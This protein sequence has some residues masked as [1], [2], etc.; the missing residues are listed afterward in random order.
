L[1]AA[2]VTRTDFIGG[3]RALGFQEGDVAFVHSSLSS[4]GHVEGGA[5]GVVR[6]L[7]KVLGPE[8][9]LAVP[10]FRR[11]FWEGPDQVWDRDHSPSLMGIISETVRAW[12]GARK[13]HHA[14]HPIAAVGRLAEDL[15]ERHNRSD[16]AFD[17]PFA[18]LLELDAWIVLMG[19]D[20]S[21]CTLIH[22]L[23]ERC[24]IP[25]RY[26]V[27]LTG[28]VVEGGA[29]ARKTYSFM[30]RREGVGNDFLPLGERLEGE[31]LVNAV[32][33]GK[34]RVRCFRARDLYDCGL[35]SLRQDPLFLVSG[36]T[37]VEAE[38][39]LPGHGEILDEGAMRPGTLL[40]PAHPAARRLVEI[41][42]LR[43]A[44][45][46]P[47]AEVRTRWETPDDLV[48]EEL[49]L[50]GG[51]SQEVPGLLA[52]PRR[53]EGRLP[54]VICLHGT[55][56]TR[57]RMMEQAFK[58]RESHLLGWAR[59]LARRGFAVLAITQFAHPPRPEPWDWEWPK[60]L[61]VYGQTA[62]GRLVADVAF[63]ADFL[64]ARPEIDPE[65][66]AVA[67]FSLGGIAAFYGFAADER[68][69]AAAVFCGG[70]GSVRHLVRK[71]RTEFHSAYFYVPG[72]VSEG[73]DHP[74]LAPALVPR[75]L[76]VC[77]AEEDAGMPVE[78]LREFARAA[79]KAYAAAGVPDR[80]RV[81]VEKGFHAM[82]RSSFETATAWLAQ[83]LG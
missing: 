29:A 73:L 36:D 79:E 31:G 41:L 13:S 78:G 75:A 14:P 53:R 58:A 63:A 33:I 50:R 40:Q 24:E 30:R 47:Q 19:V 1:T 76:I 61:H 28:T 12:P 42:H 56:G 2:S 23:E 3:L 68:L 71:G 66:L 52:A 25:Y 34:S 38:K 59:E 55:G 70:V 81:V 44:A 54:A 64:C 7:L 9:T 82:T 21:V 18:R 80:F 46:P 37:R 20:Y 65:R 69:A 60:L 32:L 15:T 22:L 17:S 51:A 74:Q 45:G 77:G 43:R 27:A 62:M 11:Y 10:I 48:L 67:G 4:F 6:A 39:Y 16:F 35:R 72:L 5:E 83:K 49:R 26:W 57:E 8:G